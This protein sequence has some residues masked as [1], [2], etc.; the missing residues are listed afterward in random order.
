M[1]LEFL[2]IVAFFGIIVV[3][4][5]KDRKN[6][7]FKPF[8]LIR[9]TKKWEN[10]IEEIA[11]KHERSLKIFANFAVIIGVILSIIGTIFLLAFPGVRLML[12]KIFPGEASPAVQRIAFFVPLWYWVISI[13]LIIFPHEL[14]HGLVS[15]IEKI[16]IT[17]V[18][19]ILFLIFPGAFVEP[20]EIKF[21]KS[22]VG[23][24]MRIAAVGSVANFIVFLL[25][26]VLSIFII[27]GFYVESGVIAIQINNESYPAKQVNL[28]GT[29][30]EI[31]GYKIRNTQDLEKVLIET[32]P[33]DKIQI[34]ADEK[35]Y[36]ITL[37]ENPNKPGKG[38]IGISFLQ[39]NL[40]S[41]ITRIDPNVIYDVKRPLYAQRVLIDWFKGL[42]DWVAFLD[43]NVA[44]AN[45]LPFL[46]FDGGIMWQALFEKVTK[47]KNLAKKMIII[48][49]IIIYGI[50]IINLFGINRI[51]R[52]F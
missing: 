21:K 6:I 29:I 30:T 14:A 46:P 9:R 19:V 16:R 10:K 51:L 8:L 39:P 33:G 28:T 35:Y 45:L 7:D 13:F 3:L 43:I 38:F 24:R 36:N 31:N 49:S 22:K 44:I 5:I 4:I 26:I 50:L 25:L 42:I 15:V 47:R 17:S 20:D 1:N 11:K 18:G 34:K 12:P 41:R 48:L 23:T 2:S 37:I 32:K 52:L 27:K 40:L